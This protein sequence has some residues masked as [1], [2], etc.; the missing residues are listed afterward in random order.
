MIGKFKIE[1]IENGLDAN[2]FTPLDQEECRQKLNIPSGKKILLFGAMGL[3]DHRK[4]G[5]LLLKALKK[6]PDSLKRSVVLLTFGHIDKAFKTISEIPIINLGYISDDH[7]KAVAFSAADIFVFPTRNDNFPCIVQESLACGTPVVSFDLN[8]VPELVRNGTTGYLAEPENAESL[9]QKMMQ[10]L[11]E[12]KIRAEMR[13]K[14]R[15][16]AVAEYSIEL[17]SKRYIELFSSIL[18]K[19]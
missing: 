2:V 12:D 14:S 11:E 6:M 16:L 3:N 1:V 15:A 19:K 5:D 18:S 17:Q 4:G 9:L 13:I 8:G 7:I 10:L